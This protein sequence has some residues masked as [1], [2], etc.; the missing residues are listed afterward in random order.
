MGSSFKPF[1]WEG[2]IDGVVAGVEHIDREEV[3]SWQAND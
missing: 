2:R 1:G 3:G